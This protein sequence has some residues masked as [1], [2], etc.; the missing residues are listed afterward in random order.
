MEMIK[1]IIWI[2]G[3]LAIVVWAISHN[4]YSNMPERYTDPINYIGTAVTLIWYFIGKK[5]KV[6]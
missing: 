3:M 2:M 1:N 6:I 4:W 5:W